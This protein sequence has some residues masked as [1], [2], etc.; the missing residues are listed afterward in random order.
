M[1]KINRREFIGLLGAGTA[2]SLIGCAGTP[3]A[4]GARNAHIV[5][6]GGGPGGSTTAKYLKRY[7]PETRVT[8][9][10]PERAFVT[11][12]GSN[13]VLGGLNSLADITHGYDTLRSKY[14]VEI[15]HDRVSGI[16]PAARTVALAGGG[17]LGYDRLVVSPG[18]DFRFEETEGF[19]AQA[20]ETLPHAWKAG[21]Q[22]ALLRRQLEAMPDGGTFIIV[23]PGNPFRCPPGPYERAGLVAHYF[24]THKPR[25]KILILDSKESFSK[26]GLFM[27]GWKARY[28]EMIEWVPG[29]QGGQV[30]SV[31]VATRTLYS[32][33]GLTHF[34]GDVINL[35]PRQHAGA[36]AH[37]AG[38]ADAS[39][40]CPIDQLTFESTL[41][42]G[43][44]VI[45]DASIA[46]AM[47]KSGHS[48]N[49]Q[50][51]L[52][53][54]AITLDLL[55][56]PMQTPSHVNTCYSLV[57]PDYGISVAAVYRYQDGAIKA[58]EGSGGVSPADAP[59]AFRTQEAHYTRG[60]YQ[61]IT[62]DIWG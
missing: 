3:G 39:G 40:W 1:T 48:A 7:A 24:K 10:E 26:Q 43:V 35:I 29:T 28:G 8:L 13:W 20:A 17:S 2:A 21:P 9:I 53:A 25:A 4:P 15:V 12:F 55:G 16:D 57:A 30:E 23:A 41:H 6:V 34:Q 18:I 14:G 59:A 22:T 49:S 46:G 47:P 52:V 33:G 27:A 56:E 45:G 51:K 42:K 50:G 58:V 61:S 36:I 11:C 37:T 38:L 60:W 62:Q 31:E 44:Y 19:S 54:A 5:I 32:Q